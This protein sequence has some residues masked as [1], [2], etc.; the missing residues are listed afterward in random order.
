MGKL[1]KKLSK[2]YKTFKSIVAGDSGN[3]RIP[4]AKK[5]AIGELRTADGMLDKAKKDYEKLRTGQI[6]TTHRNAKRIARRYQAA[7]TKMKHGD[8]RKLFKSRNK[9]LNQYIIAGGSSLFFIPGSTPAAVGIAALN[10]NRK[11][12]L[13]QR[14]KY[15][16]KKGYL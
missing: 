5:R 3:K 8:E 16:K 12:P 7:T 11:H 4:Y 6:K 13:D 15:M 14:Y 1:K 9:K 2:A 10:A